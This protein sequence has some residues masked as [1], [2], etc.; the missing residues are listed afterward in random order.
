ML[1]HPLSRRSRSLSL[2][3]IHGHLLHIS[4]KSHSSEKAWRHS[5]ER[6]GRIHV[7]SCEEQKEG[8]ERAKDASSQASGQDEELAYYLSWHIVIL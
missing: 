2:T 3:I 1:A 6:A 4:F 7:Y 8:R 5:E